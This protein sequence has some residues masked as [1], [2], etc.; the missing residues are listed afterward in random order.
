MSFFTYMS[1]PEKKLHESFV[2]S[3]LDDDQLIRI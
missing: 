3:A 2:L 1:C